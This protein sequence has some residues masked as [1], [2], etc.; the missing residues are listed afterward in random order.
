MVQRSVLA[1]AIKTIYSA[2]KRQMPG[3]GQASP[4]VAV[5]F[6]LALLAHLEPWMIKKPG[7]VPTLQQVKQV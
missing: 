6:L 1:D 3:A 4:G 7:V 5:W 2:G